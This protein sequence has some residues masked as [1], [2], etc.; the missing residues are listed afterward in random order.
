MSL[1]ERIWASSTTEPNTGCWLFLGEWNDS[2]YGMVRIDGKRTRV[3]RVSFVIH[4]GPIPEGHDVLHKCDTRQCWNPQHL[5]S[6]TNHENVLDRH[7]KGRT[8]GFIRPRR[9]DAIL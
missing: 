2:L 7:A 9:S 5:F 1:L 6:G 3:H 8:R 4:H